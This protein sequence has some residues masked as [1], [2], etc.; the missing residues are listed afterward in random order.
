[1]YR[2][3][4]NCTEVCSNG[5]WG[6]EG[7]NQ[8]I[9][10]VK[11]AKCLPEPH[12]DDISWNAPQRGGRICKYHIQRL[13]MAPWLR[14]GATQ[15]FPLPL[16]KGNTGTKSGTETEGKSIQRLP[17]LGI[18]PKCRHQTQILLWMPRSASDR[19]LIQLSPKRLCQILTNTDGD[20][21]SQP[22]DW[23]QG[24]NWRS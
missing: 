1:M 10:D 9:P 2:G 7:T 12:R 3:S 6:T 20:A 8:K 17:Q 11:K 23:A 5:G 16:S 15:P 24:H 4:R 14:D 19:I 22:S 18:H 21:H 13:G